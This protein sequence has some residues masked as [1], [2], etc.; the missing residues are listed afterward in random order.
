MWC[1]DDA[2]QLLLGLTPG[3]KS[4][5]VKGL[6]Q[7]QIERLPEGR[8]AGILAIETKNGSGARAVVLKYEGKDFVGE[9]ITDPNFRKFK[10]VLAYLPYLDNPEEFVTVAKEYR[11][12]ADQ[13]QKLT[14]AGVNPYEELGYVKVMSN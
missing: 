2:I 3:K 13:L 1:K 12:P 5:F 7:T 4:F 14:A 11:I 6:T 10:A 8:V 9:E